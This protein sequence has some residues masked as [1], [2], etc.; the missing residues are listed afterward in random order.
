MMARRPFSERNPLVIGA[1]GLAVLVGLMLAA[2]NV[3]DLPLIGGG[4]GY[5]AACRDASGLVAGNEVRI[6]GVKVGTVRAVGLDRDGS[7]PYVR[8]DFRVSDRDVPLGSDTRA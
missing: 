7:T 2:F 5:R 1:I 6:A 3:D 4:T 8:V